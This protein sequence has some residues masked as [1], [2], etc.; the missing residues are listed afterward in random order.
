M[1]RRWPMSQGV[2]RNRNDRQDLWR[3]NG[4]FFVVDAEGAE[5]PGSRRPV[6]AGMEREHA[7]AIADELQG[8]LGPDC[9]VEFRED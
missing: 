7:L 6:K 3:T 9:S 1:I 2:E 5:V 8:G 4:Y